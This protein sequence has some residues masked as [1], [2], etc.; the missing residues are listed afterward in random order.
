MDDTQSAASAFATAASAA[1]RSVGSARAIG[2]AALTGVAILFLWLTLRIDL[3]I[4]A[5]ILLAVFLHGVADH[6]RAYSRLPYG[7]ALAIV[8]LAMAAAIVGVAWFFSQAIA[9]QMD[10]LSRDLPAAIGKV[11]QQI[12]QLPLGRTLVQHVKPAAIVAS[13]GGAVQ[14]VFG[15]AANVAEIVAGIVVLLFVGLYVAAEPDLY[16]GGLLRLVPPAR[17]ERGAAIL[18]EAASALWYWMLGRLLSMSVLG[19]LTAIG[20]WLLGVPVPFA[21]G[22]LAGVLTFVPYLGTIASAIPTLLLALA[23]DPRL[24][25]YVVLLYTGLHV[26]EGY[27]LVPL[28]QRRAAHLPPALTL[29]VQVI[30]GVLAG[31][32]GL[33]LA[34]PLTAA[35]LVLVRTIYVEDILGDRSAEA[36]RQA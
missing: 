17:R 31:I 5:G 11:A 34:T 29:S 9:S 20:L 26:T 2:G 27:I 30:F 36:N 1:A 13:E 14:D 12:G 22:T 25:I 24:A 19:T 6:V 23:V 28:V 18:N 10:Q 3:V 7:W 15:V 33:L 8:V 16:V 21:L 35:V 32:V 4:F